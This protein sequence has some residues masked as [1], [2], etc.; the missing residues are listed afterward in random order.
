MAGP[1]VIPEQSHINV[2]QPPHRAAIAPRSNLAARARWFGRLV[3]RWF[4]FVFTVGFAVY[5][6]SIWPATGKNVGILFAVTVWGLCYTADPEV[7]YRR[8]RD[9]VVG[10]FAVMDVFVLLMIYAYLA[11]T[12]IHGE[13]GEIFF[14][15]ACMMLI[16][17]GVVALLVATGKVIRHVIRSV[18]GA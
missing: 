11:G 1:N 8:F 14:A 15:M 5:V 4:V 17:G 7:F 16:L 9:A 6:V 18:R 12:P 2:A 13:P 3:L 10:A